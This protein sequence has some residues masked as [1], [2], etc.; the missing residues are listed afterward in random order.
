MTDGPTERMT[1]AAAG[2][3]PG[4]AADLPEL[5]PP[6]ALRYA[7]HMVLD[8]VGEEGQR[9]LKAAKVL[10]VG[11]G[12]LGSPVS[13]YLAAAGVGT[14]G[15]VD[16]DDVDASNLQRQVLYGESQIGTPK[17][18]AAEARLRDLNPHIEIRTHPA[19]LTS[20]NALG[21]I[22]DYDIVVDGTDNFPT[23]YLVNDACVLLGK[24]NVYGS[25]LKFEGQVSV[26]GGD[27][28][29]CYRC[30]FRQPPP[31]GLVPSCAE[32]GVL[33]V[34]PGVI[35]SLQALETVKLITGVGEPL[36]GRLLLFDGAKMRWR[37]L[38]LRKNPECP[39]CGEDPT[40]TE[41][42]DY[43]VFCGVKSAEGAAE[44]ETNARTDTS[45]SESDTE[46]GAGASADG[47]SGGVPEEITPAEL[48]ERLD[49]GADLDLV[50]VREPY[51][52]K[53]FNLGDYGA[54]LIPLDQ[55]QARLEG[56]D[57][58]REIVFYCRS[59][60]R[61]GDVTRYLRDRGWD[62][63]RNLT[64]GILRWGDEVDPSTP[65]Y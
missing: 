13:L 34:L 17:L 28:A 37:E 61:S 10:I 9:R 39:V 40:V 58:D 26:F 19:R 60:A 20:D 27:D 46:H 2:A 35:G 4:G 38:K 62:N 6:E 30:L 65:R 14:L 15:L 8:D 52:W 56:L 16:H 18:A 23:R 7:R 21:I 43:E 57:R 32:G 50:D 12:G 5:T 47:T 63:V 31:P 55:L 36:V 45:M 51:E 25:I 11:A 49:A 3:G 53:I 41:L 33:G 1:D 42:I 64:G 54:E 22:R 29:P 59:G 44:T 48:K 24:R